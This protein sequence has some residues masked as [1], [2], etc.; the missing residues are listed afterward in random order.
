MAE[1][2]AGKLYLGHTEINHGSTFVLELPA[3]ASAK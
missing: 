2:M 1:N 3:Q